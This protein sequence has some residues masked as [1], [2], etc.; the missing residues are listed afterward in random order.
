MEAESGQEFTGSTAV[1]I[2]VP[3]IQD[4]SGGNCHAS[5]EHSLG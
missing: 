3:V 1:S 2:G 5:E 4:I